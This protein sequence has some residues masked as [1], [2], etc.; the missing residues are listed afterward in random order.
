MQEIIS[1]LSEIQNL[2]KDQA[3][4]FIANAELQ[5][6]ESPDQIEIPLKHYFSKSVYAREMEMKKGTYIVGKIHKHE[7]MHILS[8]GEIS[9][10]SIDGFIRVKAP[11]TWVASAGTKRLI[12]AHE[13]VTWTTIHGTDETDL[14][15]IEEQFIAK[16]YEELNESQKLAEGV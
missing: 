3:R 15:K 12:Y 7:N 11:Y 8:K 10:F 14:G 4:D 6:R 5:M 1:K 9:V 16:N 13:D 2:D